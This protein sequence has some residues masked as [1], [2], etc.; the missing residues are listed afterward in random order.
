MPLRGEGAAPGPLPRGATSSGTAPAGSVSPGTEPS[1]WTDATLS[2]D[3]GMPLYIQIRNLLREQIRLG[4]WSAYEPMPTEDELVNHFGVSRTTVRQAMADLVNEGLVVRKAGRGTFARQPLLVL[5]MQ[6]WHSVALDIAQRG[7][8]SSKLTLSLERLDARTEIAHRASEIAEGDVLHI[9]QVR[10]ADDLPIVVL[11]H[12]FPFERCGFLADMP[13]DEPTFSI[14]QAL[15]QHGI[16]LHSAKGEISA[17]TATELEAKYLQVPPGTPLVEI[18]TK[19]YD[20]DGRVV[21][22]SRGVVQTGRYPIA[23]YSDWKVE[24]DGDISA[25]GGLTHG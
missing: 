23:L 15:G 12:Y 22:Y 14:Q 7:L 1:H 4:E 18:A 20:R 3:T 5:R 6:Q 2:A 17:T 10:Y 24:S 13:V 11:D 21:E 8:R 25:D 9:Q 16:E 19:T